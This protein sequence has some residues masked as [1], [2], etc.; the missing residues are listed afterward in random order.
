M[1]EK[2]VQDLLT[3]IEERRNFEKFLRRVKKDIKEIEKKI[4]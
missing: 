4:K 1:S 3:K 2:K